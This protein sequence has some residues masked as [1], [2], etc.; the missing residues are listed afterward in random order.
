ML[1]GGM[2]VTFVSISVTLVI[3]RFDFFRIDQLLKHL[4]I[5]IMYWAFRSQGF[6]KTSIFISSYHFT[7]T[8]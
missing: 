6:L 1:Q 4:N 2:I 7:I 3:V 5:E 8:I